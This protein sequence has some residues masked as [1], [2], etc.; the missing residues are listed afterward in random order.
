MA[1][2]PPSQIDFVPVRAEDIIAERRAFWE[3]F[4]QGT[5][6]AIGITVAIL[7]LMAIFLL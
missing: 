1:E 5:T 7:V 2:H 6:W 3:R 4:M